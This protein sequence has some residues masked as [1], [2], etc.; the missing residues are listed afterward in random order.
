MTRQEVPPPREGG[1]EEGGAPHNK[2]RT[3][4]SDAVLIL[5]FQNFATVP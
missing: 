3:F 5:P 4:P 2:E 1:G